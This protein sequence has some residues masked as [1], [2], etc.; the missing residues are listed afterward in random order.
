MPKTIE[1]SKTAQSK[2][3][4]AIILIPLLINLSCAAFGPLMAG[5]TPKTD[6]SKSRNYIST[7]INDLQVEAI[8]GSGPTL[9]GLIQIYNCNELGTNAFKDMIF[10][11]HSI[12]FSDNDPDSIAFRIESEIRTTTKINHNCN[13]N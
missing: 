10:H 3:S 8:K 6:L 4:K 7:H 9:I 2:L 1:I 12:L 11:N 13:P 5:Y